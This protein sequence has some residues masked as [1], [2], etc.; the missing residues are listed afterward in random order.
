MILA[1]DCSGGTGSII[2]QLQVAGQRQWGKTPERKPFWRF[3]QGICGQIEKQ[4]GLQ[5]PMHNKPAIGFG[6]GGVDVVIV[7]AM[8]DLLPFESAF[9]S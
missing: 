5:G 2:M 8:G 6:F 1:P 3:F 7:D 4:R 9:I